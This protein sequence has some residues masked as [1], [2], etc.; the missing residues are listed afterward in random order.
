MVIIWM[1]MIDKYGFHDK[2]IYIYIYTQLYFSCMVLINVD[3]N[4]IEHIEFH[5]FLVD[6]FLWIRC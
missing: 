3:E 6:N 1:S 2:Y 5:G 4:Q